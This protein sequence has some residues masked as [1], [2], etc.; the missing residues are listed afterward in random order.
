MWQYTYDIEASAWAVICDGHII[1]HV[2]TEQEAIDM[3]NGKG[4]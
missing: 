2:M 3:V 1:C 4:E